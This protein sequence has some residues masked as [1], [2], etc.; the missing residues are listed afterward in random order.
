MPRSLF[1]HRT[2]AVVGIELCH[3]FRHL[4][5][6]LA[7]VFLVHNSVLVDDEGRDAGIAILLRI[8]DEGKASGHLSVDDVIFRAAF[9]IRTLLGEDAIEVA[10]K[11]LLLAGLRCESFGCGSIRGQRPK[12]ALRLS[13]WRLPIQ[14]VLLAFVADELLRVLLYAVVMLRKVFGL[15]AGHRGNYVHR[16]QF[17]IADTPGK[18]LVFSRR[19]VEVPLPGTV[20]L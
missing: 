6:V 12:R 16:C 5:G 13:L 17:V 3:R 7:E 1:G 15:G 4:S 8:G 2:P 20:I 18:D 14:S 11:W 19:G 10:V 9:G